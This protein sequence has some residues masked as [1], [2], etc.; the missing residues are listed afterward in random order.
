MAPA[1]LQVPLIFVL[2]AA[3]AVAFGKVPRIAGGGG[4]GPSLI[5]LQREVYPVHSAGK[6]VALKAS[7]SGVIRVGHP[8]EQEFRMVFDTGSGHVVLPSASCEAVACLKHRRYNVSASPSG[9]AVNL[10]GS[11]VPE[12]NLSDQVTIGFGTGKVVGEF[13]HDHVCLG[14]ATLGGDLHEEG[15]CARVHGVMAVDMSRQPFEGFGFDGI[16]G[17]GLAPLAVSPSFSFFDVLTKSGQLELPHF[18][19]FMSANGSDSEIAIGGHNAERAA[20]PLSWVPAARA[21][22]GHW[23]VRILAVHV[24]GRRLGACDGEGGC[25]GVL[26][27]GTTHLGVPKQ[28]EG[29]MSRL[30]SLPAGDAAD[31]RAV[32]GGLPLVIELLGVNLTV[33]PEHYMRQLPLAEGDLASRKVKAKS[34]GR[35]LCKPKTVPVSMPSPLGPNLFILGEPLLQSYYTVFD[36]ETPRVGFSPAA[37]AA[38]GPAARRRGEPAAPDES[39][40]ARGEAAAPAVTLV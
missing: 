19:V 15:P 11:K 32:P 14:A 16:L 25:H 17:L 13:F 18:G 37:G 23:Q 29:A 1:L 3:R 20:G 34:D 8:R 4:G 27:T 21:D 10:D 6:V 5:K 26:D 30:L 31:C 9:S 28:H 36:W 22:M 24:G 38:G 12:G 33:R 40:D 39:C 7:Y 35:K 2:S